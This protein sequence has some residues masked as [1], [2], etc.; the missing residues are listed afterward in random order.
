MITLLLKHRDF[1]TS[2]LLLRI[3]TYSLGE[4]TPC[5]RCSNNAAI[6]LQAPLKINLCLWVDRQQPFPL[7]KCIGGQAGT[8]FHL[9]Q[10]LVHLKF[11]W[12]D[13]SLHD[14]HP[15]YNRWMTNEETN[16]HNLCHCPFIS[17]W[18]YIASWTKL[19]ILKW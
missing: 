3:Y 1:L 7:Y 15:T 6:I 10:F 11:W 17:K 9:P 5:C 14:H 19:F 4:D 16:T 2:M 12:S 18:K 8:Y 13:E